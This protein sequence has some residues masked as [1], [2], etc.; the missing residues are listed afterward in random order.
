MNILLRPHIFGLREVNK[1]GSAGGDRSST[2]TKP[3][4]LTNSK[5]NIKYRRP[6]FGCESMKERCRNFIT[7]AD[8][9]VRIES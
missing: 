4:K 2:E 6:S 5:R 1:Q 9:F 8:V 3:V 7:S